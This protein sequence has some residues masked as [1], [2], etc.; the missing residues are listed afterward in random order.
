M[1]SASKLKYLARQLKSWHSAS[2]LACLIGTAVLL[3]LHVML[4]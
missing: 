1:A 2:L 3:R 4:R